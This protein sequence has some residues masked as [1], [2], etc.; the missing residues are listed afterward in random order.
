MII[1]DTLLSLLTKN[2]SV[3]NPF[4]HKHFAINEPLKAKQL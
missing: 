3:F 1:F 4:K 2:S